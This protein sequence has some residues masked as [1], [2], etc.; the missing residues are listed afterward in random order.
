MA[1]D[2]ELQ[3]VVSHPTWVLGI[4]VESSARAIYAL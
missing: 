3:M 2:L 4:E 1:L